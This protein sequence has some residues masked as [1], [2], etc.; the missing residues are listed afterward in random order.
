M[1]VSGTQSDCIAVSPSG[2]RL[3]IRVTPK[4]SRDGVDG[5][6]AT[7]EGMA[8]KARVRAVPEDGKAN[9]AAA[10]LIAGWLDLPRSRVGVVAGHRSR[11]KTLAIAGEP[12]ALA[13]AIALRIDELAKTKGARR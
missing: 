1:T 9:D 10:K 4:S 2:V 5:V 6:E 7:A 3:R 11:T 8:L 13:R 12:Q